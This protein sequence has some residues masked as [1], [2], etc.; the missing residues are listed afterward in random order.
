M[1]ISLSE[2]SLILFDGCLEFGWIFERTFDIFDDI[3]TQFF[4]P[5]HVYFQTTGFQAQVN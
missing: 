5:F 2:E 3:S 1:I 4:K